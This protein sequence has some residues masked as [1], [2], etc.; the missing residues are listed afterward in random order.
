MYNLLISS[1][2]FSEELV[3][4]PN[5]A[6]CFTFCFDFVSELRSFEKVAKMAKRELVSEQQV[7]LDFLVSLFSDIDFHRN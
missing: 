3:R 7:T 1:K 4:F 6:F 2:K 5:F